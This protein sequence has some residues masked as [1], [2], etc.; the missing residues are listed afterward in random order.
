VSAEPRCSCG[1]IDA[2]PHATDHAPDCTI[3]DEPGFPE[4]R[5]A[6]TGDADA[7]AAL[8]RLEAALRPL[9]EGYGAHYRRDSIY[10]LAAEV[11]GI[12]ARES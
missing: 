5:R 1:G 7:L 10:Y 9:V 12:E 6:L 11:L 2:V 3:W 8:D 4:L